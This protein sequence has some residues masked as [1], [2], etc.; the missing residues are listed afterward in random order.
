MVAHFD[1]LFSYDHK[2]KEIGVISDHIFW[3]SGL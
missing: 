3:F 2:V 1:D